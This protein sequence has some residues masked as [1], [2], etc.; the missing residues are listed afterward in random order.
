MILD[1]PSF[2]PSF[3]PSF[4][5]NFVSAQYPVNKLIEFLYM[6]SY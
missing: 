6:H 5:H 4:R 3:R 1:C 2:S